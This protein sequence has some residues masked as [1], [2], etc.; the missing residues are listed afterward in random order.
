MK[1]LRSL[2]ALVGAVFLLPASAHALA[3]SSAPTVFPL[4]WGADAGASY[5]RAIPTASQIGIQNGAASLTDGFPP[6]TFQSVG[7]GGIPPFGQD[8]NGILN[9]ITC[10]IRWYDNVGVPATWSSSYSTAIGGY[11]SGAIVQSATTAGKFWRSTADNNAT[12]PDTGGAGWVVWPPAAGSTNQVQFNSGGVLAGS[13]GLTWNGSTLTATGFSGPLT[14]NVTGNVTGNASTATNANYATSAGT[15]TNA[16]ELGG[17][18]PS[19]WVQ[20]NGTGNYYNI[21]INGNANYAN[22]AGYASSANYANSAGSAST[23]TTATTAT[24]ASGLSGLTGSGGGTVGGFKIPV[25]GIGNVIVNW[26]RVALS[27]GATSGT[28]GFTV[29]YGGDETITCSIES[30]TTSIANPVHVISRS[31]TGF[32]VHNDSNAAVDANCISIGT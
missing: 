12:N 19:G 21:S 5:I 16:N 23:A 14:G 24:T 30:G 25:A 9:Q 29:N 4:C 8:F 1:T 15:A 13:S 27:P 20:N 3:S 22:S 11:P 18:A 32:T 7:A 17:I 28:V 26:T 31:L 2:A 6:L 10:N